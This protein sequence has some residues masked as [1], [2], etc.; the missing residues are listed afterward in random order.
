MTDQTYQAGE[1]QLNWDASSLASGTYFARLQ[2]G[3]E[4]RTQRMMLIK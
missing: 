1:H 4:V 2:A 3:S